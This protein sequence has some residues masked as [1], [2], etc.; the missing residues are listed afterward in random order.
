MNIADEIFKYKK[1]NASKLE[2]FGFKKIN[3]QF[4]YSEKIL[5]GTMELFVYIDKSETIS[6]KIKDLLSGDDY[7]LHLMPEAKGGFVG[8]VR[9][10]YQEV[11]EKIA[12]ECFEKQVFKNEQTLKLISYV[13]K[14]FGDELEFLWKKF[15]TDAIWRRKDSG[16]W[17]GLVM[18]VPQNK[19]YG[20]S[21]EVVEVLNVRGN[22]E[23]LC[24]GKT[25]FPGYHMNKKSWISI[26]LNGKVKSDKIFELINQSY[27]LAVK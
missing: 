26:I 7:V 12:N 11:L 17:Y 21:T 5:N 3:N 8:S 24:D 13:Q 9:T 14:N 2:K 22:A 1:I 10:A 4:V 19:I 23:M 27:A 25:I 16:K 18:A 6:T 20:E 15:E